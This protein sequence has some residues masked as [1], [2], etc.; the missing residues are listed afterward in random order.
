MRLASF[1]SFLLASG[2]VLFLATFCCSTGL[3]ESV[4]TADLENAAT[5]NSSWLTYGRDYYGQRFVRLEQITPAN[6]SRLHPAWVF[7]TG[8][9]NRGL[10]ATPLIHKGVLYVSADR[11]ACV[12]ARRAHRAREVGLRPKDLGRGRAGVLLRLDQ[13]RRRA[14][15]ANWYSSARWMRVWSP[16]IETRAKSCGKPRSSTGSRGTASPGRRSW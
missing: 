14:L 13:P 11:I 8:G 7:A 12:C 15:R 4:T 9:E 16:S 6:V 1:F 2:F 10:Q 5:D 3:A